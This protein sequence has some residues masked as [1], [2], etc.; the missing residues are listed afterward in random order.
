MIYTTGT[1]DPAM[2]RVKYRPALIIMSILSIIVGALILA[3]DGLLWF[4]N[5]KNG[6]AYAL[7]LFTVIQA[8][9][10]GVFIRGE[11]LGV[12]IMLAWSVIYLVLLLLNPLTGP[13]IGISPD[14]FALYLFG[15][16][17]LSGSPGVS[18]PFMCPPFIVSYD[19]LI[20]FQIA[21]ITLAYRSRR[22]SAG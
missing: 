12:K 17:P 4:D 10:L 14:M 6:H 8:A 9:I 22:F 21:I 18:C 15:V 7:I 19:L 13:F 16:A 11:R 5:P 1:L 20:V 3:L 2:E